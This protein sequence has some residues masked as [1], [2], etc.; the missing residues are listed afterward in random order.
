M[1]R[2]PFVGPLVVVVVVAGF[3]CSG[4]RF[5]PDTE[6]IL[7]AVTNAPVLREAYLAWAGKRINKES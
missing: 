6:G 7:V 5:L 3:T 4:G 2:R 1:P